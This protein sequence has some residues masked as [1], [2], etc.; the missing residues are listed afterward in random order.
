LEWAEPISVPAISENEGQS[1]V[2]RI[3]GQFLEN[4]DFM[5][6][7]PFEPLPDD[8]LPRLKT[9]NYEQI[10]ACIYSRS[11]EK[12]KRQ[13]KS[14]QKLL[15]ARKDSII[16]SLES[17]YEIKKF[18][19]AETFIVSY[20]YREVQ[21][22]ALFKVLTGEIEPSGKL[23]VEIKNFFPRGYRFL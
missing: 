14:I 13:A 16:V 15:K 10:I 19:S 20:G 8:F 12:A 21:V 2:E 3:S 23:P 11:G 5:M 9:G 1:M 6:L 22:E 18:P 7:K 17:P 4:R